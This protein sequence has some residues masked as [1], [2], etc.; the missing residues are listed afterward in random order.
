[1]GINQHASFN[2]ESVWQNPGGG[3]ATPC[4]SW[5]YRVTSCLIFSPKYRFCIQIKSYVIPVELTSF[6]ATSI[7]NAVQLNWTTAT[8]LNNQGFSIER[9]SGE[10]LKQLVLLLDIEQQQKKCIINLLIIIFA[11]GSY[12][13]RL[14][15]I[16]FDEHLIIQM[17]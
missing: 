5:G 16:D 4:P 7:S 12:S 14:K 17:L 13:Y 8:E 1:M 15:Q 3:F 6:T 9:S 11:S 2:S 10:D